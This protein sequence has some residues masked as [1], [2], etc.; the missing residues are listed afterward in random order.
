MGS[1]VGG[2]SAGSC[3]MR[4]IHK[5]PEMTPKGGRNASRALKCPALKRL[6]QK[7]LA[8]KCRAESAGAESAGA[9]VS[10]LR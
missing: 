3:G 10:Y 1:Q 5:H 7:C 4:E 6:A 2:I 8:L 9:E